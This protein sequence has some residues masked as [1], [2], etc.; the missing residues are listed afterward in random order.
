MTFKINVSILSHYIFD[1]IL[2]TYLRYMFE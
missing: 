1:G 2:A